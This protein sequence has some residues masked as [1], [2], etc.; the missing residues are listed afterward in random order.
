MGI[1]PM[2]LPADCGPEAL[3]LTPG[4]LIEI[5]ADPG[6][7]EPRCP[8]NVTVERSGGGIISFTATAAIETSAEVA[9]LKAGGI[10]P[11]ILGDVLARS[12]PAGSSS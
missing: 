11:L 6:L 9:I 8:I 12:A 2:R 1:L 10:V 4:D 7:I 5:I 3:K